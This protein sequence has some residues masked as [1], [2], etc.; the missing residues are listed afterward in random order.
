MATY[1]IADLHGYPLADFQ[2]LLKRG[3]FSGGDFLFVLGDVIDRNGDG[4]I[5]LL[6]WMM[7]QPNVELI[8]GNHEKMML[9]SAFVFDEIT[10][11]SVDELGRSD[12]M[13]RLADWMS[14]GGDVTLGTLRRL[15]DSDP[16]LVEEIF[17]YCRQAPLYECV[18]AGGKDFLLV[19]AGLGGFSK[20]RKPKDYAPDELLWAR[21]ELT[22]RYYDSVFTVLGHTPTRAYGE[23]YRGRTIRTETWIDIDTGAAFGDSPT[24]LRLDDETEFRL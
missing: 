4:G 14:N 24:L 6:R 17:D 11:R 23:E 21:P 1:A 5:D 12:G 18:T 8:L 10:E 20:D 16:D 22:D 7:C 13:D 3:G 2:A 9:D 15:R 19:H